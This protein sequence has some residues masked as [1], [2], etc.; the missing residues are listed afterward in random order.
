MSVLFYRTSPTKISRPRGN[1]SQTVS[2]ALSFG[3]HFSAKFNPLKVNVSAFLDLCSNKFPVLFVQSSSIHVFFFPPFFNIVIFTQQFLMINTH[4]LT[5]NIRHF[6]RQKEMGK[7][8]PNRSIPIVSSAKNGLQYRGTCSLGQ[9]LFNLC[10]EIRRQCRTEFTSSRA[11][12]ASLLPS[13]GLCLAGLSV[14]PS[15]RVTRF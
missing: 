1:V 9:I 6:I 15:F 10:I 7:I 11:L 5:F 13:I 4:P 8:T 2:A 3:Y 14:G 12:P